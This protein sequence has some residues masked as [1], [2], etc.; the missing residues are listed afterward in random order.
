MWFQ[1]YKRQELIRQAQNAP[2]PAP[3]PTNL[4]APTVPS[5]TSPSQQNQQLADQASIN[6]MRDKI[7]GNLRTAVLPEFITQIATAINMAAG[8][9]MA[10]LNNNL[11]SMGIG[12]FDRNLT[13]QFFSLVLNMVSNT[14][15]R[16]GNTNVS[17]QVIN[18]PQ[19]TSF[20]EA[21]ANSYTPGKEQA[22]QAAIQRG[23]QLNKP[24]SVG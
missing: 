1:E 19:I 20:V 9:E 15:A 8:N 22:G 18:S 16:T 3:A 21:L 5:Q 14:Y 12:N 11:S 23:V 2:P 24:K 17:N 13:R 4:P 10:K 6:V 7:R